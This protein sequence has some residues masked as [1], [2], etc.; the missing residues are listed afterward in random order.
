MDHRKFTFAWLIFFG[1]LFTSAPVFALPIIFTDRAAFNAAVGDTTLL[2]LDTLPPSQ[3]NPEGGSNLFRFII[4]ENVLRF[5]G[6]GLFG[7]SVPGTFCFCSPSGFEIGGIT[8]DPVLAIGMD[9]TPILPPGTTLSATIILGGQS[10][11]LTEP[12]FLGFLYTDPSIF[13]ISQGFRLPGGFSTFT[14]DNVAI[15]TAPEPSSVILVALAVIGLITWRLHAWRFTKSQLLSVGFVMLSMAVPLLAEASPISPNPNPVGS[16]IDIINDPTASTGVD[17][18]FLNAGTINNDASS[19]L[20]ISAPLANA[21]TLNNYGQVSQ[22]NITNTGTIN[23]FGGFNDVGNYGTLT[24]AV[25][26]T[27]NNY[28]GIVMGPLGP[29]LIANAGTLNNYA[30]SSIIGTFGGGNMSNTGTLN[31]F[32]NATV[33]IYDGGFGNAVGAT[34]IT[35]GP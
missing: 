15:K 20:T 32:A 5:D 11:V 33:A 7:S 29:A 3:L 13:G 8:V 26:A 25:G 6:E 10:F 22:L 12:Q 16:T 24:N 2:T 21:G 4:V 28:G 17:P 19:K 18:L 35:Q 30:G 23:N 27:L 1:A 31:N 34:K 9:I 14:I